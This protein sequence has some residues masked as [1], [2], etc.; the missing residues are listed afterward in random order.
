MIMLYSESVL[1]L[2]DN[3]VQIFSYKRTIFHRQKWNKPTSLYFQM[4][5]ITAHAYYHDTR[6][7]DAIES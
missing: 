6:E 7:T 4:L 1:K 2:A 5:D 3:T